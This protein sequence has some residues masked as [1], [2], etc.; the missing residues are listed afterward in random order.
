[1][2]VIL[3]LGLLLA[4]TPAPAWTCRV[5]EF[6][7]APGRSGGEV[8]GGVARGENACYA[9]TARAGQQLEAELASA[10]GNAVMQIYVPGW[11]PIAPGTP[12]GT[13]L[14]GTGPGHDARSFA[15]PLPAH[16]RYLVVVGSTRGG[17]DFTLKLGIR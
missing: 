13:P 17:S 16:G 4:A 8:K 2:R 9:F 15:G 7:F 3:L 5:E 10:E 14:P 6:R 12:S 1:M 11:R